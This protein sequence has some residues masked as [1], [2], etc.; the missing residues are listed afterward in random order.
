MKLQWQVRHYL[1]VQGLGSFDYV[2]G[3]RGKG[4]KRHSHAWL[5]Q[6][7]IIVDITADQFPEIDHAVIVSDGSVWHA[8]FEAEILHEADFMIYDTYTVATLVAV[9]QR[10]LQASLFSPET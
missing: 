1:K 7:P 3:K 8:A 6:G 5:Q 10:I 9:Y 2:L 4:G